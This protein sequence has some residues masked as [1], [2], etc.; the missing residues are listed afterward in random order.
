MA[1]YQIRSSKIVMDSHLNVSET[2]I[3]FGFVAS[4]GLALSS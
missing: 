2:R 3:M 1:I 4:G